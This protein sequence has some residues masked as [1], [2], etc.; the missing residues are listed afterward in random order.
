MATLK[1]L[2]EALIQAHPE[3]AN[4]QLNAFQ[5]ELVKRMIEQYLKTL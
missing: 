4:K 3:K 2:T 5:Y 1:D